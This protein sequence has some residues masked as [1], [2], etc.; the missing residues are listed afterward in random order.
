MN[1][2]DKYNYLKSQLQNDAKEVI[3]GLEMTD[4]N[5]DIA[6]DLLHERYGKKQL[7]INTH[8]AK[9]KEM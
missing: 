8:Y 1:K 9:L 2:E 6:V 4:A 3:S 5:Y 7:I